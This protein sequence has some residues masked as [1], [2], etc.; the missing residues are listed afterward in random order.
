MGRGGRCMRSRR[1][2]GEEKGELEDY[3]HV[4]EHCREG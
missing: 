1:G 3:W 2:R 4:E